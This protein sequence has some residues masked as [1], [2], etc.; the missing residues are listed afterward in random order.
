MRLLGKMYNATLVVSTTSVYARFYYLMY[1]SC[2]QG[3]PKWAC[4]I[5]IVRNLSQ[6][7]TANWN[8]RRHDDEYYPEDI[9]VTEAHLRYVRPEAFGKKHSD[10]TYLG[11]PNI[12]FVGCL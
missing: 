3:D 7:L 11:S 4:A 1:C 12:I 5:L 8:R 10:N 2:I 9:N 6:A